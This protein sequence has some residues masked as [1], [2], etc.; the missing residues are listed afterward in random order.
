MTLNTTLIKDNAYS[1][2]VGDL[3]YILN[4]AT[5][6]IQ[7]SN[8][9]N[10]HYVISP[11]QA[12]LSVF[13]DGDV[14]LNAHLKIQTDRDPQRTINSSMQSID[15]TA[16]MRYD[17]RHHLLTPVIGTSIYDT[18]PGFL[19]MGDSH[20]LSWSNAKVTLKPFDNGTGT[21]SLIA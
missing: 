5:T 14:Y 13:S 21:Y 15:V 4:P 8:Y 20:V 2:G 19:S 17:L 1:S 16:F 6:F 10:R 12:W 9:P 11:H 3:R 7:L 18:E